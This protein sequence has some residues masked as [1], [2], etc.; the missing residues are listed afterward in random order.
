[1]C[2]MYFQAKRLFCDILELHWMNGTMMQ[3]KI[4]FACSAKNRTT[5]R[6]TLLATC[7][8]RTHLTLTQ[9]SLP[10]AFLS[11]TKLKW[12]ITWDVKLVNYILLRQ[13]SK[14]ICSLFNLFIFISLLFNQ[15][16]MNVCFLC[17]LQLNSKEELRL[18]LHRDGHIRETPS[19]ELW[20]Q[21]EYNMNITYSF[22]AY[23]KSFNCT[24]QTF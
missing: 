12:S 15:T 18:H 2:I 16:L 4:T 17:K 3:S 10:K 9:I 14:T 19:Q 13:N 22:Y 6:K 23:I 8:T 11:T 20:D 5:K 7:L 1:M 24:I 21:P